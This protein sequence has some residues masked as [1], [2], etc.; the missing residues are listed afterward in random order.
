MSTN[1][2]RREPYVCKHECEKNMFRKLFV[3]PV[4]EKLIDVFRMLLNVICIPHV[5]LARVCEDVS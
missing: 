4:L 2:P 3:H 1:L 5:F